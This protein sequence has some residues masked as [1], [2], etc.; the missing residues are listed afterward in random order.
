[1]HGQVPQQSSSLEA[2]GPVDDAAEVP[3][4]GA[5]SLPGFRDVGP[6]EVL[7]S[8]LRASLR[9]GLEIE[10]YNHPEVDRLWI[11]GNALG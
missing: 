9:E 2:A 4:G 11:P 6:R 10:A 7:G 5:R 3:G 8:L 1:M